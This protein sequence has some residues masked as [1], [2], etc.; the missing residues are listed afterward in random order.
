MASRQVHWHE[1]MFL[2]PQHM[3]AADRHWHESVK[4]SEEWFHPFT[5]GIRSIEIERDEIGCGYFTL[6]RC[7]ARFRDG[8]KITIP[9]EG[10]V[11]TVELKA[12]LLESE[13]VTIYL[14]VPEFQPGRANVAEA[15]SANGPRYYLDQEKCSDE[16]TGEI[17]EPITMRRVRARLLLSGQDQSG[18][19]TLPLVRITRTDEDGSPP[20]VD[21][22]YVPPL[23]AI[24]AWSGLQRD[25][26]NLA[27]QI[28]MKVDMLAAHVGGRSISFD[29]KVP[30]DAGRMLELAILNGAKAKFESFVFIPGLTPLAVYQSLCELLGQLAIFTEARKPPR[31]PRYDHEDIGACFSTVLRLIHRSLET[32]APAAYE[33]RD[34]ER[35]GDSLQV[36]LEPN[37]LGAT[38]SLYLGV[39]T[40]LTDDECVQLLRS[41]DMKLGS[42][43]RVEQIFGKA[44]RGLKLVP[45]GQP[46]RPLPS[47]PGT[48][49]YQIERDPVYW[50]EV[51]ESG[52]L[53]A[54]MNSGNVA[55]KGERILKVVPPWGTRPTHLQFALYI[56]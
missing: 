35:Q 56:V 5:W 45:V 7:Q 30:G 39:D 50:K 9:D 14:A 22:D 11:D 27:R 40:E 34:F 16:N 3:Q 53:A 31:I 12:S 48:V 54:W 44:K 32:L 38:R 26:Q 47:G 19:L 43:A 42:S 37:W 20:C 41:L 1:G 25:L 33:R 24:D 10:T 8:T 46:P 49:Y 18:Y 2:R 28:S 52:S 55:F 4:D 21:D 6:N 36:A 23:L 13:V 15:Q 17:D 29:S 51:V